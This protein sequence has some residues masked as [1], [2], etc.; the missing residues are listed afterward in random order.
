MTSIKQQAGYTLIEVV[1]AITIAAIVLSVALRAGKTLV[2]TGRVEETKA[3]MDALA[4]AITGNARLTSNQTQNEFGYV[5]DVGALP[6]SLDDLV[7]NPGGYTT[8]RGPYLANRFTQYTEDYKRD[9]WDVLYAYVPDSVLLRSSGSGSSFERRIATS[10]SA[11]L[12]NQVRGIILDLDATPPGNTYKD[13]IVVRLSVPN[14]VGGTVT[15]TRTPGADGF[16]VF[17]SIPVGNHDIQVIYTPAT[18]SVRG[19]VSVNPASSVYSEYRLSANHWTSS[20][21][22]GGPT[23]NLVLVANSDTVYSPSDC[24][25]IKMYIRNT[26]GSP[27][28][29]TSFRLTWSS[30]TAYFAEAFWAGNKIF[31]LGG[32]PRGVSGTTYTFSSSQNINAGQTIKFNLDKFGSTNTSGGGSKVSMTNVTFTV[33]FSDGS[34]FT[35]TFQL[36]AS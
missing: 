17:D 4:N 32:T 5:G 19:F 10:K 20:T 36:C 31:D 12:I 15:K 30:P 23:G 35:E 33:T 3:E 8:W 1:V 27:I 24:D 29:V 34:S 28:T 2:D 21:G 25:N 7:T 22:G 13:S 9:G 16:F 26:S 14:G 11:L 6:T 18:D